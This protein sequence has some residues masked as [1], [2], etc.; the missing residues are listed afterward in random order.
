MRATEVRKTILR[1]RFDA[2]LF[3]LDGVITDTAKVHASCW[4]KMFDNFLRKRAEEKHVAFEPF[5]IQEDYA[6][7][8]DGKL[9]YE[10]VR[11][12]LEARG[13]DLPFGD[14]SEPPGFESVTKLGNLKDQMVKE[15]IDAEGIKVY[16]D[17]VALLRHLRHQGFRT[18]L[19][20]ASKNAQAVLQIAGIADLFDARV[21]GEVADRLR[22]PGKPAPDTFLEAARQLGSEPSRAV[23][24]EDALSGVRA[25]RNGGFGL[26]IGV[27]RKGNQEALKNEGADV[28]VEDLRE[29]YD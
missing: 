3:D 15:V 22:L 24:I 6:K 10:G 20:S 25:G 4:K 29:L 2:V 19:V 26:V 17:S 7:Y 12:F 16:E 5:D 23:V 1:E 11:S 21:D 14:P 18:S 8:V 27:A 13:I 28:V 9:R